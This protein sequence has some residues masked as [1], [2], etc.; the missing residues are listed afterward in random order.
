MIVSLFRNTLLWGHCWTPHI[1]MSHCSFSEFR[2]LGKKC[3]L[4][5]LWQWFPDVTMHSNCVRGL[6]NSPFPILTSE[7]LIQLRQRPG[8]CILKSTSPLGP[9]HENQSVIFA[10]EAKTGSFWF[11]V[12]IKGFSPAGENGCQLSLLQ[13]K[14]YFSKGGEGTTCIGPLC[15]QSLLYVRSLLSRILWSPRD[16]QTY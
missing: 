16:L 15:I 8:T 4:H 12:S 1:K 9:Y 5:Y 10:D 13:P 2:V 14:Q 7:I 11:P 3:L 6:N